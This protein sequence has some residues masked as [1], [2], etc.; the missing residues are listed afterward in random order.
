MK[1]NRITLCSGLHGSKKVIFTVM[2]SLLSLFIG[3]TNSFSEITKG[4]R[5][6]DELSV[7]NA[8][9]LDVFRAIENSSDL[10]FFY[11]NDQLDMDKRYS[12]SYKDM[13]V[14]DVLEQIFKDSDY[15]YEIVGEHIVVLKDDKDRVENFVQNGIP[16][17]GQITDLDGNPVPGVNV[18]VEG[19]SR[20][21]VADVDGSYSITVDDPNVTLIFSF[22]GFESIRVDVEG[23]STIDVQMLDDVSELDEIVV[24]GYGTQRR[25]DVTGSV[26][27]ASAD[28]ILEQPSFNALQGL[29]GKVSG[30]NIFTNSGSPTG[31][32]RVMIRGIGTINSSSEPLYVVDGVVM[33]NFDL[34]NP[35]DIESIEV[36][37]DAS[38]TAIYGARGANGVLLVTTKR[39]AS[40]E[41]VHVSYDTYVSIGKL[42]KKMD[43]LNAEEYMQVQQIGY[44][45]AYKYNDYQSGEG[46][47]LTRNDPRLFD[48]QGN[49]RYDT[50]WQDEATRTAF[51]HNHQL[52][53]QQATENSSFGSFIN[54]SDN[55]G[56]MLNSWMK[57]VNA[58]LVYD[59]DIKDWLSFG[60]NLS[61]N[62]TWGN[63]VEEGGGHQAPRRAMIE[64]PAIFPVKF[65]DGEWS[66]TFT[67][68]DEYALEAIPNPVHVLETQKRRRDNT[69]IFGNLFFDINL[70][71]GLDLRTQFGIDKNI[72][73]WRSYSPTDLI[74]I[75]APN[76]RA[77]IQNSNRLYWQQETFLNYNVVEGVHR[78]SGVLGLSWQE[79]KYR[80]NSMTS[81]GFADD[82]FH[83]NNIGAASDP[84]AP[85]SYAESWAMNSYFLRSSYT[86]DERYLFTL[87]GRID[88]SSRFGDDNKYAFFPSAG[89]GWLVSNEGFWDNSYAFNLLKLRA[90]YG[91]TGNTEIGTYQSLAT[92]GSGTV[93]L[94]GNRVTSSNV[95]RLANPEL[96]WEKT[97][98]FNIGVDLGFYNNRISLEADY[99]HKLT[100]DL[101]LNRP[102]PHTTGFTSILDNIGE[103]SNRGLDLML[104]TRNVELPDFSWSSSLNFNYNKNEIEALG[105]NDEDIHPGPWWVSG[106]QTILRVGESVSSFYGY[107]RLGT[108]SSDEVEEA[109]KVGAVPGEAKRT[110]EREIIGK[111]IPDWT[112]SFINRLNYRN[113]DFT[114]DLQFVFGVDILQQYFH[115]VEDRT[116]FASGLSTIL[117]DGWTEDNQ[118]TMV[119]QIRHAPTSGQNSEVDDHWVCDGSYLRGNL[120][121]L[122]YTF[123]NTQLTNT[124]INSL[125]IYG[126][127]EN[128][129][130]IHSDDFKGFDP[131]A[132]SWGGDQWGQ[133]MFFFQYPKPRTFTVGASVK[134]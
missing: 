110:S 67:I 30:V 112:G 96:E 25:S 44:D 76:G 31:S 28:E 16:V 73:E 61:V 39:G 64:M 10:G 23:R 84:D 17:T 63:E 37:K 100:T 22:V 92:V 18:R 113:W 133:N 46:P 89:L 86:Y 13:R 88:G 68:E 98:Q 132:T 121:S 111:G 65:P 15:A 57:R 53:I 36:L 5:L 27:T 9:I 40:E 49:P 78:F 56:I 95:N 122:G 107:R 12:F 114:L 72:Y 62:K 29:R 91:I 34:V 97:K 26:G 101:L 11:K 21:T 82:F 108:W 51:S 116:G 70:A 87:T 45:N 118:N 42:R 48:S 69:Q 103:V 43:L 35:N 126:S 90:S 32:T 129:F 7:E 77:Q 119:Q 127:I 47:E 99:Y 106:S 134:F 8:M 1:K 81:E 60:S 19:T 3:S 24:V 85:S 38:A 79:R 6:I 55:E 104:S 130:V 125:R 41:G 83:Y 75:S 117:Y 128:A 80:S 4:Q 131:E 20:G 33:E 94:N 52:S 120:I 74:N 59:A 54:Y 2:F 58:K 71:S 14:E 109:A 93:L 102:V 66:S 105:E 124:G 115:S 50:D 123:D